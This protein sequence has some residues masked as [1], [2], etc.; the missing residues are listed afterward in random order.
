MVDFGG[1]I[2][3]GHQNMMAVNRFCI[4]T[5]NN[6]VGHHGVLV[7]SDHERIMVTKLQTYKS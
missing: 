6:Y 1:R 2:S 3:I 7:W 4:M 5:H